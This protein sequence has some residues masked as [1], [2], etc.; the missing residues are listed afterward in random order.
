MIFPPSWLKWAL[1]R[2]LIPFALLC[3]FGVAMMYLFG[4]GVL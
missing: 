3:G 2:L 4:I 1:N